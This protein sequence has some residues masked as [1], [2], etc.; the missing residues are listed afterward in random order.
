MVVEGTTWV[1][2]PPYHTRGEIR[3]EVGY[4]LQELY[5]GTILSGS[6][7]TITDSNLVDSGA[8]DNDHEGAWVLMLTGSMGASRRVVA[9]A[10]QT[11]TLTLHSPLP[12]E[13]TPGDTYELHSMVSPEDINRAINW[14][15]RRMTHMADV[16]HA[17]GIAGDTLVLSND[18]Y[19]T[20]A[21][22]VV[23]V[24]A[25]QPSTTPWDQQLES[26]RWWN[27]RDAS[28]VVYITLGSGVSVGDAF[29]IRALLPY[30]E[31]DRDS[32]KTTAPI[33]W[34][35]PGVIAEL[36]TLLTRKAP[37][38]DAKR[39]EQAALKEAANFTAATIQYAPRPPRK[40]GMRGHPARYHSGMT[41]SGV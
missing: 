20:K 28:G 17:V 36:Y 41:E 21:S 33:D 22:Q 24:L 31:L 1:V 5:Q 40:I 13:A 6:L 30:S 19:I 32:D 3:Q 23:D 15:L 10:K 29:I 18:P 12:V 37:A 35:V 7:T 27:A 8:S 9:Y 2:L 4:R 25:P 39:F 16:S 38:Q 34:L 11:G 14:T 26:V